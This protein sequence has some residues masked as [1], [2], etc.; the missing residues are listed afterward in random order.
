MRFLHIA[1]ALCACAFL[2]AAGSAETIF[3]K[4]GL[5]V[6][7]A[8]IVPLGTVLRAKRDLPREKNKDL[9]PGENAPASKKESWTE[10]RMQDLTREQAERYFGQGDGKYLRFETY[11]VGSALEYVYYVNGVYAGS[12]VVDLDGWLQRSAGRIPDGV[13]REFYPDNTVAKE[14][15]MA[16][17][18][19]KGLFR[20]YFNGGGLQSETG[21]LDDKP[22][23]T[24]KLYDKEGNLISS[25]KYVSGRLVM[26]EAGKRPAQGESRP[27]S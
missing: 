1:P 12:R 6:E 7:A 22:H 9:L 11:N 10:I 14:K 2:A 25:E 13:Y 16:G 15:V 19:Q 23:G 27:K 18:R 21:Y 4:N 3:L 20:T 8:E 26:D 5:K 24:R 17:G